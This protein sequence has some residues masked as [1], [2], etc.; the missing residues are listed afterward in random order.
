[1]RTTLLMDEDL[2]DRAR[3]LSGIQRISDLVREGLR[4]LIA[5]EAHR[6]LIAYGGTDPRASV[7]ARRRPAEEA[8]ESAPE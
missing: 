3:E 2:I 4:A 8:A 6:R 7:S 1:M 5:R